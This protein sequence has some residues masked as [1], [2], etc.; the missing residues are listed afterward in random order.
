M[1]PVRS[2]GPVRDPRVLRPWPRTVAARAED[3]RRL[4]DDRV[5]MRR[6]QVHVRRAL[7]TVEAAR[8]VFV[9]AE[10]G[11]L[12]DAH[13]LERAGVE[14]GDRRADVDALHRL[15]VAREHADGV[16]DDIDAVHARPPGRDVEIAQVVDP[17][18]LAADHVVARAGEPVELTRT[19]FNLLELLVRN[20]GQ[21]LTR[22]VILDRIWGYDFTTTS[23]S[24]EVYV[25]YL[26]R[27]TEA[28]GGARLI[29]TVRGVG[30]VA[31]EG[32]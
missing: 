22:E 6:V 4:Q 19:E 15:G 13:A 8:G 16:Q 5:P 27:K 14:Q 23:N 12:D 2:V 28:G 20:A 29:Q 31:R 25:G 18:T 32:P 9:R 24:L 26:R 21:V 1:G 17:G 7:G 10:R 3:E 11:D 30:Y